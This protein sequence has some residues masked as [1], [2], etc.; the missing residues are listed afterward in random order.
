MAKLAATETTMGELHVLVAQT[1]MAR[2]ANPE[3][4]TP[5][6]LSAAIRFLKDNAISCVV[7]KDNHMGAL[8]EELKGSHPTAVADDHELMAALG[9]TENVLQFKSNG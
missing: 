7:D 5:A 9:N 1:M 4:C 3:L 2:I 8:A 6:D